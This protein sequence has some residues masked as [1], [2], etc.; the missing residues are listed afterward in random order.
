MIRGT[1]VPD[2]GFAKE[3]ETRPLHDLGLRRYRIRAEKDCG[4]KDSLERGDQS[5]VLLPTVAH[6]E[7]FQHLGSGFESDRLTFLLDGQ[8][9]QEN[10]NNP[11]LSE[12]NSIVRMTGDLE[13]KLAVP[14][15]VEEFAPRQCPTG[16][17]HN[18]KGREVKQRVCSPSSRF[19]RM[20]SIPWIWFR[21]CF[22]M[23]S[24]G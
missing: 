11:I 10:G 12:G 21:R 24:S 5:A 2:P 18:T 17:P 3:I 15:L 9:R 7:C 4:A 22:E 19:N 8:A 16:S 23:A 1:V 6:A 13:N 14:A 20:S